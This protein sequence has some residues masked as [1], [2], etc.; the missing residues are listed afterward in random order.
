MENKEAKERS[1]EF[2]KWFSELSNKDIAI[3]GGKGASLSEMYNN[4]FPIPPGFIITAQAYTYLIDKSGL[5]S[6]INDIL[7]DLDV[8]DTK[9]LEISAKNIRELIT[10]SEMPKEMSDAIIEA[11]DILDVEKPNVAGVNKGAMD[12][13]KNAHERPFV[14]VRSSATTEDLADASFAGQQ[15]SFLNVKGDMNLILSVKKCLAS[16]FTARAVYYRNKKGFPI[17]GAQLAV[18]VQKMIDSDKSGVI[19]SKNPVSNKGEIVIEAVWGLGEGIVSGSIKPDH[20]VIDSDLDKFKILETQVSNKKTAVVRDSSGETQSI[21]LTEDRAKQQVLNSFEIKMLSQFAEQLENHY[22]KPQDIEF[23]INGKDIYIVQSRPITTAF[24][25]N[26]IDKEISGK[27]LLSGLCA[28]PGVGTGVVRI[29][30]DLNELDKVKKGDV[31]VTEMTNPD[32]VISMQKAAAIV[33]NEGGITSHAAIVSREMGI[34]CIVGTGDATT[35]LVEGTFITVDG[36]NGN[37]YEGKGESKAAEILPIVPTRTKIKVIVDLP[38]YAERAAKSGSKSVGLLRLEGIISESGKHPLFFVKNKNMN[39]YIEII[40]KGLKKIAE[41]FEEIWIRTSDIRSDEYQHLQGAPETSEG[42]PMLGNHGVRF[43]LKHKDIMESEIEAM[44][45]VAEAFPGKKIGIMVPQIISVDELRQ[46]KEIAS[47]LKMPKNV[48]IGIMVE[49]PAAVQIINGLCEEGMDFISFGTNDLTQFM[50]A[51]DRNNSSVQ[52]LYDEMNPAVLSALS[53]VIRRC[54]KYTV[55]TSICGQAGSKEVM[56]KFLIHEGID[57]ITV[58]A[59]AAEKVSKLVAKIEGP[60]ISDEIEKSEYETSILKKEDKKRNEEEMVKPP[61]EGMEKSIIHQDIES[62]VLKE[63]GDE[64]ENST[65]YTPGDT[66]NNMDIP[67]LNDAITIDSKHF[68]E[69]QK[70]KEIVL[71]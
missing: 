33:T 67:P 40:F 65:D 25:S 46:T 30:H 68:E 31:L 48:K 24:S 57:S 45:K 32:M 42:N 5:N 54:K 66:G 1:V 2:I 14:A 52:A 27:V 61:E 21:K 51:I 35:K 58:N 70:E 20:Y 13:L 39:E 16:L 60:S 26:V 36:N 71:D 3:A 18:V 69:T 47:R 4:K 22:K 11:Y 50:L 6:K 12:I 9:K 56:A 62:I 55:E 23:A 59:D 10:N 15:E 38:D 8:E 34:P 28:S 49:T 43:S 64:N 29:V 41:H 44:K 37:V 7:K 17:T 63:L 53:Y 19:F